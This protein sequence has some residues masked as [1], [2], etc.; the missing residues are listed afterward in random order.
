MPLVA[1]LHLLLERCCLLVGCRL[2]GALWLLDT[3]W[4]CAAL[5]RGARERLDCQLLGCALRLAVWCGLGCSV[6]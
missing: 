3:L 2:R 1:S 5:L 4:L 6:P